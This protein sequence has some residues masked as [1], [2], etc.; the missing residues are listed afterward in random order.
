MSFDV[1]ELDAEVVRLA[2]GYFTVL[3]DSPSNVRYFIGDGRIRLQ[4]MEEQY[5]LIVM[6]AFTSGA[7]PMHL[8]TVEA[9][10]EAFRRLKPGGVVAYHI[11]NHYVDL[12]PVLNGT[13]AAIGTG[14]R[15]HKSISDDSQHKYPARWVLLTRNEA[16]LKIIDQQDDWVI[17]GPDMI[18]WRDNKSDIRSVLKF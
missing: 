3:A 11:S 17:P 18:L 10:Q 9:M 5:D 12:L 14:I 16:L 15:L 7:I 13:A 1:F 2:K 8:L 6:D 4:Q